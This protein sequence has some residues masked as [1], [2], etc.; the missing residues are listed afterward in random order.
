MRREN[1]INSGISMEDI[2]K[3]MEVIQPVIQAEYAQE[4]HSLYKTEHL[5]YNPGGSKE[6]L[7]DFYLG[8][9][10]QGEAPDSPFPVTARQ[11]EA[12]IRLAEASARVRLSG[13]VTKEDTD[14]V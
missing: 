9:R 5:P 13:M 7:I 3:A 6:H 4:I 8:L 11:L 14:R 2:T 1:I 12:L 10:K